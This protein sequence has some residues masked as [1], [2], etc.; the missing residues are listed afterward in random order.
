MPTEST[1][2]TAGLVILSSLMILFSYLF[3]LRGESNV[4]LLL[5]FIGII[6]ALALAGSA[7]FSK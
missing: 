3:N 2:K 6:L 7:I 5:L 1:S 4:S